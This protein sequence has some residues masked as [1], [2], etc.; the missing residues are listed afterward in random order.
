MSNLIPSTDPDILSYFTSMRSRILLD[1]SLDKMDS[2]ISDA[3]EEELDSSILKAID[4]INLI[5]PVT[6]YNTE[7]AVKLAKMAPAYNQLI[8]LGGCYY[9]MRT[10]WTEW[11][12]S[13]DQIQLS[14]L[15]EPDRMDRF[16]AIMDEFKQ[17]L[18]NLAPGYKISG[19]T[20]VSK[21]A[22]SSTSKSVSYGKNIATTRRG[23]KS[24]FRGA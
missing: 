1:T 22:Y 18:D 21:S 7:S 15:S 2:M 16:K 10:K 3:T 13:G 24:Q 11:G 9:I 19:H 20:R 8:L 6:N 4:Y 14:I 12:H 23:F 5:K 17:E